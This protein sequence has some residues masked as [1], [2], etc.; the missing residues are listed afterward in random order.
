MKSL[1]KNEGK[2]LSPAFHLSFL[3]ES[4]FIEC[5]EKERKNDERSY[6]VQHD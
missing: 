6:V 3:A 1:R 2:V 4:F 5:L